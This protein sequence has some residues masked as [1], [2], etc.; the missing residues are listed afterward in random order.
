[1]YL[2]LTD[3][4]PSDPATIINVAIKAMKLTECSGQAHTLVTCDQQLYKVLVDIKWEFPE[5][6]K[7]LISHLRGMHLLMSFI[8]CCGTLM[9]NLRLCDLLRLAFGSIDK[10]LSGKNFLQNLRALRM[11]V[12]ELLRGSFD[13]MI[14]LDD[15]IAFLQTLR[16]QS[17]TSKLWVDN[18]IRPVFYMLFVCAGR[19]CD[20]PL[21]LYM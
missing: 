14:K 3:A 20:W 8:G 2:P 4:K 10:M 18:V 7:N 15:L 12:E 19:E 6:F 13:D 5:K 1:M 9:T 17:P 21:H 11:V 16:E